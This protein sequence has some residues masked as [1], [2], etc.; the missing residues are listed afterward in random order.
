VNRGGYIGAVKTGASRKNKLRRI[1]FW[2]PAEKWERF[3]RYLAMD[4]LSEARWLERAVDRYIDEC[5][6][7]YEMVNEVEEDNVD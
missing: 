1:T 5:A 6:K 3:C 4:R 7:H 2:P